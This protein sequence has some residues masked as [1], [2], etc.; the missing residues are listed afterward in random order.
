[1]RGAGTYAAALRGARLLA[2]AAPHVWRRPA[3]VA[4]ANLALVHGRADPGLVRACFAHFA[5]AFV[6]TAFFPRVF[7]PARFDAHF[8]LTGPGWEDYRR[9][10]GGPAVVVTGHFGNWEIYGA[11]FRQLGIP[12]APVVRPPRFRWLAARLDAFRRAQGQE[13][14]P[15]RDALPR[16]LRALR[17]GRCVAFLND[18]A[19]GRYGLTV[20]F[21]GVPAATFPV[22]AML[23]RKT[24]A[25]LYAG[26]S[27]RLGDGIRYR[28]HA[29]PVPADGD[30]E[31]VT[32]RLND[33]L[34]GYVRAAPEQWWW[35]H[36]RFK[37]RREARAGR[38][39]SPAGVPLAR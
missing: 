32:R 1:M 22:P 17:R 37:P 27:T 38:P 31:A 16:A 2:A 14:I 29:E 19:A 10:G 6:D 26:Y 28:C 23:A 8:E 24:G 5:A 39:V 34:S 30:D 4:R 33:V 25:P 9:R 36:R 7:D 21:L 20:P 15:K 18:Q 11:A 12:L 13:T 35:F 3:D